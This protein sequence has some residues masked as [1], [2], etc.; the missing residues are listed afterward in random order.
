MGI[1]R[2]EDM[3]GRFFLVDIVFVEGS[4]GMEVGQGREFVVGMVVVELELGM[5]DMKGMVVVELVL[6]KL[7]MELVLGIGLEE[8][9]VV[10]ELELGTVD[11]IAVGDS[12]GIEFEEGMKDMGL[13]VVV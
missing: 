4:W 11:M 9:M 2:V 5:M 8:G 3:K 10:V 1:E 12:L 13:G 6:G 7:G